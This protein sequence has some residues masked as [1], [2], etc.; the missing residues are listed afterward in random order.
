MNE[1]RPNV[2]EFMLKC[3]FCKRIY[4]YWLT[5]KEFWVKVKIG[6]Y[7]LSCN[8]FVNLEYE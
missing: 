3:P 5:N 4:P 1:I 7:C 2:S 8:K 6:Q